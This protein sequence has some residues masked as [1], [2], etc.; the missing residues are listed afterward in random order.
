MTTKKYPGPQP[1]MAVMASMAFSSTRTVS[2]QDWK[3]ASAASITSGTTFPSAVRAVI[4][5][6]TDRG[7]LGMERITGWPG[8]RA[9]SMAKS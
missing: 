1:L 9:W 4:P 8:T 5:I 3:M 7:V 6:P 2:P